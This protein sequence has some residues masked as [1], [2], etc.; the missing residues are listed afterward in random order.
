[1]LPTL[2]IRGLLG[3]RR[4]GGRRWRPV[5]QSVTTTLTDEICGSQAFLVS[6]PKHYALACPSDELTDAQSIAWMAIFL[7][8]VGVVVLCA[9]LLCVSRKALLLE[10][11]AT[12]YT[13]S[14][15]FLHA[16]FVPKFFYFELLELTK[17]L[18]L[19]GFASACRPHQT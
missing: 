9:S 5:S 18:I 12:P 19:I 4:G 3:R 15:A 13:R 7:Y 8:P 17:K 10:E 16:P 2:A 6:F 14:I 1:M 11:Q